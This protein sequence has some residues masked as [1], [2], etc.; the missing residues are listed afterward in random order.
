MP[1]HT[2]RRRSATISTDRRANTVLGP[3]S[4]SL[5][6]LKHPDPRLVRLVGRLAEGRPQ[7]FFGFDPRTIHA[8]NTSSVDARHFF[9]LM[10]DNKKTFSPPPKKCR[11]R[12]T[13]SAV[14]SAVRAVVLD[15]KGV[16]LTTSRIPAQTVTAEGRSARTASAAAAAAAAEAEA[17]AATAASALALARLYPLMRDLNSDKPRSSHAPNITCR[18]TRV[19][20][21]RQSLSRAVWLLH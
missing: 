16:V 12:E 10:Q 2:T 8:H 11:T 19:P 20:S 17:A 14:R 6:A 1:T 18:L 4:S 3:R 15:A 9:F 13:R 7:F 5:V 21:R